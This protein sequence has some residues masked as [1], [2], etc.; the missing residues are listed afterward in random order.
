M[1][2]N[3]PLTRVLLTT[4][5]LLSSTVAAALDIQSW[6]TGNG[7]KVLFVE[8]REL[9]MVDIRLNFRAGSSRDG[10]LYG[11]SRLTS[12]LLVEGTGER[13]AE[14]VADAFESVGAQLGHSSLRDMAWLSLRS[15][16]D[17]ELLEPAVEMFARVAG[18]PSFPQEA[19][20]RDRK[21]MLLGLA[22]RKK[23]IGSVTQDA[24]FEEVYRNHPY[25]VGSQGR[26]DT[27]KAISREDLRAFHQ[28]YYAGRNANLAIVGDLSGEQA[29]ELATALTRYLKPGEAASAIAPLAPDD[30]GAGRSLN[31]PFEATQ[32]HIKKGMPVMARQDP[33]FFALYV[34]N[35]ILGGSGFSSRLMKEIRE[36]RGLVYSVYSYFLPMESSGPFEMSLQTSTDQAEEAM[37]LLAELLRS[38]IETGPSEEELEHAK[39]NITGGFPLKIDSNKKIVEYLA[40]MGFYN[41][42]LDYLDRFNA[43]INA[44]TAEQIKDAF[45]RRVKPQDMTR[46]IVGQSS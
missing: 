46:I 35:H 11:V 27:L 31:I 29:R 34:G 38:F 2:L 17:P 8:S 7:V 12:A 15:L 45:Q 41:L 20:E 25:Q 26:E 44:V 32:T 3:K 24:F 40:L 18:L 36:E 16:S 6:E 42:D 14:D 23:D 33:D 9:P 1:N 43:R 21:A 19:I 30:H 10:A 22:Q 4:A 39:S 13:S 28:Q 5:L 37:A